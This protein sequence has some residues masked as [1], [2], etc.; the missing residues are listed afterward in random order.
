M[1]KE[2]NSTKEDVGE[3]HQGVE[4][5]SVGVIKSIREKYKMQLLFK[6]T[7]Y[8]I[9]YWMHRNSQEK[10]NVIYYFHFI[11]LDR[12]FIVAQTVDRSFCVSI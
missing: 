7:F 6:S 1:S 8:A 11:F 2:D 10:I 5:E 9:N 4:A 12:H 3:Q